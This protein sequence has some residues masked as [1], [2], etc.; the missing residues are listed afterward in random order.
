MGWGSTSP[1]GRAEGERRRRSS[2]S[3]QL[4]LQLVPVP[5]SAC[6]LVRARSRKRTEAPPGAAVGA[7]R[8]SGPPACR[9]Q[10]R[11][12]ALPSGVSEP[13]EERQGAGPGTVGPS[14]SRLALSLPRWRRSHRSRYSP[15]KASQKPVVTLIMFL[16]SPASSPFP[17]EPDLKR[18]LGMRKNSLG[19]GLPLR[20]RFGAAAASRSPS[21]RSGSNPGTSR[22]SRSPSA[23]AWAPLLTHLFTPPPTPGS[24]RS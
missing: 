19:F 5:P 14:R 16:L 18:W 8:V 2:G 1:E 4:G 11:G 6:C 22:G 15:L 23:A 9:G 20:Q 24:A 10:P 21:S 7:P 3:R 13:E 12:P 17:R